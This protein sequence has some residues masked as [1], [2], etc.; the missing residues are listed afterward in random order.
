MKN[1]PMM[2]GLTV[3]EDFLNYDSG[4]Y[5]YTTGG[6]VGGHAMKLVGWGTDDKNHLFWIL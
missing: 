1:G 3:F 4:I 2:V 6:I 5:E